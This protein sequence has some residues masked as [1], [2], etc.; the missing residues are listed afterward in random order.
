[1]DKVL[2]AI[3]EILTAL[4]ADSASPLYYH[5]TTAP[6]GIKRV[7]WGD[8]A[9]IPRNEFPCLVIRPVGSTWPKRGTKYDQKVHRVEVIIVANLDTYKDTAPADP[10]ALKSLQTMI[11]M[12]EKTDN[13]Q[14]T[15]AKTVV[16][17]LCAR[18]TL[19][20]TDSGTKYAAIDVRPESVDYVFNTSRGFPTFEVIALFSV[21]SQGD[22]ATV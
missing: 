3:R 4:V 8:P 5:A 15:S 1:M 6:K 17:A 9:Q 16:G 12:M 14:G 20:Y 2:T 22:R 10:G 11:D 18:L 7:F 21:T 19:P 13:V